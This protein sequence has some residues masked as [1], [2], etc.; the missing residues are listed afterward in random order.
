M[1][2]DPRVI[3]SGADC[4]II[5]E[6]LPK[7]TFL[8]KISGRDLGEHGERPFA[9]LNEAIARGEKI[10]IFIDTRDTQGASLDVSSQWAGWLRNN[11]E[12]LRHV[13]MLTRSKF[14]QITADFVSRFAEMG[15][16]MRVY[17]DTVA[18]ET[19]LSLS[20]ED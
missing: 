10:E 12:K 1:P 4:S 6:S 20:I 13:N 17:T 5:I 9:L 2:N 18:F 19:A 15:D 16:R 14:V 3:L 7:S 8:L 11:R